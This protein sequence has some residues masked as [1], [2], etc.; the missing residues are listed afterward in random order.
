MEPMIVSTRPAP[1]ADDCECIDGDHLGCLDHTD[2]VYGLTEEDMQAV[3]GCK[4]HG[5]VTFELETTGGAGT[6]LEVEVVA[7][8]DCEAERKLREYLAAAAA[9]GGVAVKVP[10]REDIELRFVPNVEETE[11]GLVTVVRYRPKEFSAW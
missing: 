1:L 4:D 5:S 2:H 9:D 10:G 8:C 6:G 11:R 7:C 3:R